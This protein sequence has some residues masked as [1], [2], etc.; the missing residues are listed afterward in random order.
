MLITILIV[1]AA[2]LVV[3]SIFTYYKATP[4]DQSV[5]KR[6]WASVLLAIGAIGGA[7]TAWFSGAPTP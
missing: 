1:A 2:V 6:V 3:Y 5:G 7:I 4:T